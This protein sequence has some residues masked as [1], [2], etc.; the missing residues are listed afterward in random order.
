MNLNVQLVYLIVLLAISAFSAMAEAALLSVS[1]FKVKHWIE[2]K[3]F[4]AV[5]VKKLKDDPEKLLSTLLVTNNLVNTAAAALMTAIAIEVFEN[6]AIG[7]ATGIATFLILVVGD[8]IPKT[9]GAN[10][11][12]AVSLMLAPLVW[13][14][15]IA[16]FPVIKLLDYFLKGIN[17]LVGSKKMPI[18]T[19]EELRSIIKYSEE[20]GSIKGTEKRLIQRVFDFGNITVGDVMTRKKNMVVVSSEMQIKDVLKLTTSKMYSRFPVY[21][22]GKENIVGILYLKDMLVYSKDGKFDVTVR[23]IMRKPFFVFE[24]KK[25]DSM[26]RLFQIRKEHMAIVINSKAQIVGLVTIENILEE[27]VGEIIDE[28][29]RINPSVAHIEKSEWLAKGTA[30]IEEI[31]ANTGLS[32]KESDFDNLDS[33]IVS[34]LGRAPK[35]GEEISYQN[36]KILVEDVQG[37]KV[38]KVRIFK[39]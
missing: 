10:N 36:F 16:L 3:K 29:D 8:I 33:F 28:S 6:N 24:S 27:I 2:K 35:I 23:Q 12:E 13:Q 20:E 15:S 22:K 7:I 39:V 25:V 14:L 19:K 4:G 5:Y 38:L 31:N 11:N 18:I 9:I 1:R 17:K 37:K 21:E 32:I 34:T 26:L 30:E